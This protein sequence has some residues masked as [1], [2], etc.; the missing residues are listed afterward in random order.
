MLINMP[1]L[2]EQDAFL[3]K[4]CKINF[5]RVVVDCI[6]SQNIAVGLC[7]TL[8]NSDCMI[9]LS[10]QPHTDLMLIL[11]GCFNVN[12]NSGNKYS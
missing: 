3:H 5:R 4:L 11:D 12:K 8:G 7:K 6:F 2:V 1:Y 10:C 9:A